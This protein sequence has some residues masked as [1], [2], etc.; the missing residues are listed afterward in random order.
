MADV[1]SSLPIRTDTSGGVSVSIAAGE[2]IGIDSTENTVKLDPSNNTVGLSGTANT[3]KIDATNNTV[4]LDQ[5]G[6]NNSVNIASIGGTAPPV[7]GKIAIDGANSTA[8]PV[9][10]SS[11]TG[12]LKIDRQSVNVASNLGTQTINFTDITT[13]TTGKIL[14]VQLF[15]QTQMRVDIATFDGTTQ[16]KKI[17]AGTPSG[18][19]PY[20][21]EMESEIL[22]SQA[23]GTN[24]HFQAVIVNLDKNT[25]ADMYATAVWA[26]A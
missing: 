9:V 12:T 21:I 24:K 6:S 20:K 7:A 23:G 1:T 26:E 10:I 13:G 17:T 25:A 8:L 19:G 22:I 2:V 11:A 16:T 18:G 4:K 3:V 5:T 14:S 15:S